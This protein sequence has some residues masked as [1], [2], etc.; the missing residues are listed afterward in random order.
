MKRFL[1]LLIVIMLT[2]AC[3]V[4]DKANSLLL[5]QTQKQQDEKQIVV[6]QIIVQPVLLKNGNMA[7][8]MQNTPVYDNKFL[9]P[10]T[11]PYRQTIYPARR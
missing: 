1:L 11:Y 2:P 6:K 5:Q 8:Q 10:Y 4:F 7:Q 3:S 9:S